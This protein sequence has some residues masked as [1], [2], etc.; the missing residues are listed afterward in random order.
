[1][2]IGNESDAVMAIERDHASNYFFSIK[3]TSNAHRE[4]ILLGDGWDF[5]G[6]SWVLLPEKAFIAVR[7]G[8]EGLE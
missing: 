2:T 4:Y 3:I 1:M 7:T 8:W 5:Q 6:D